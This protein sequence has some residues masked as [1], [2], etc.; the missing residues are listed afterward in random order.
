M[1][2]LVVQL[3]L[4]LCNPVDPLGSSV[5]GILQARVLEW[6]AIPFSRGSSQPRDQPLVSCIADRF[7]IVWATREAHSFVLSFQMLV[8]SDTRWVCLFPFSVHSIPHSAHSLP[9]IPL[10]CFT[11]WWWCTED[12]SK[13]VHMGLYRKLTS[14]RI[15]LLCYLCSVNSLSNSLLLLLLLLLLFLM[16]LFWY[17]V[18]MNKITWQSPSKDLTIARKVKYK[19][20][21]QLKIR[22]YI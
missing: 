6:V 15:C 3:C 9:S 7:F 8:C 18:N 14:S 2:M 10:L 16:V 5:H 13:C 11:L 21:K 4:T 20:L 1:K 12:Q 17:L 19:H 22:H